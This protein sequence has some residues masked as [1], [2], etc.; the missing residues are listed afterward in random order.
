MPAKPKSADE[1]AATR[2]AL[3][4]ATEDPVLTA[5]LLGHGMGPCPC[6]KCAPQVMRDI[7]RQWV[8]AEEVAALKD[9]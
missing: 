9:A 2:V 8:L 1:L 7:P 3:N 6:S 4:C 5:T